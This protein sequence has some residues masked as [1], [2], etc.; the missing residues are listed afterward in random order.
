MDPLRPASPP[1]S[2][3]SP[4]DQA[5][6][7]NSGNRK[8]QYTFAFSDSP[9]KYHVFIKDKQ[10]VEICDEQANPCFGQV[11]LYDAVDG[12]ADRHEWGGKF[13]LAFSKEKY[14]S[15]SVYC[16][17]RTKGQ[18]ECIVGNVTRPEF[19]G[20]RLVEF[21]IGCDDNRSGFLG[22]VIT[23]YDLDK[24]EKP[25]ECGKIRESVGSYWSLSVDHASKTITGCD[26]TVYNK[27]YEIPGLRV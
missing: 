2:T 3:S 18:F 5:N 9:K 19:I 21:G 4:L 27:E 1:L 26:Q 17:D 23:L 20:N 8:P 16:F 25:R 12:I 13:Y 24:A 14:N 15:Y 10:F 22:F 7:V 11:K 6:K